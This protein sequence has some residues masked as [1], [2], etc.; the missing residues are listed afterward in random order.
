MY[1]REYWRE[2]KEWRRNSWYNNHWE[3]NKKKTDLKASEN[4]NGDNYQ[5]QNQKISDTLKHVI[6]KIHKS[7]DKQKILKEARGE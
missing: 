6:I 5:R 7:K 1:N 3:L 2:Q 4:T